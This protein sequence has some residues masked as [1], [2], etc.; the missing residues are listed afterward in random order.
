[1]T[2]LA[3]ALR[4]VAGNRS[5]RNAELAWF[6]AMSAQWAYFVAALVFAYDVGGVAAAGIAGTLRMLPAAFLAPF[7]TMLADRL[8]P[9][10]VL[11]WLNAGR[12]AAVAVIAIVIAS[13]L[14]AAVVFVAITLEGILSTLNR[15]THVSLLPALARSPQ[16]LVAANA[17]TSSGEALGMLIGPFVGGLFMAVGGT[18]LGTAVPALAFAAAALI[19]LRIERTPRTYRPPAPGEERSRLNELMAGFAAMRTYPAVGGLIALFGA[20]VFVRG[21]LTVLLVVVSVELLGLGSSGVGYLNAALGAG[22]LVGAF[23]AFTLVLRPSLALPFSAALGLWGIP[24]ILLGLA[25]QVLLAFL[26]MGVIGVANAV[27]D[28]S[29]ISLVQRSVPTKLRAR[30]FG[31]GEAILSLTAGIGSLVAPILVAFVSLEMAL[32]IVGAILPI[33]AVV[34]APLVR[35]AD[36]SAIVPH[37]ELELLRGVPMFA[38]LPLTALEQVAGG[39]VPERHE[40]GTEVIRQ[41]DR[42]DCWYLIAAGSV[43]VVHD[44][45]WL[46]TLNAGEAFGEI[47]LLSDRPRTATIRVRDTIDVLRLPRETFLEALTGSPRAQLAGDS[48]VAERLAEL[49]EVHR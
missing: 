25:P 23:A 41:G 38:P 5:I 27:M 12:F 47:A 49:D 10:L 32:V 34:S 48:V 35:R 24:I 7:T 40:A 33:L 44:G 29:G 1:M 3:T 42:G 9:R 2:A 14:P 11:F 45:E 39:L 18:A 19:V 43:D 13:G 36:A 4:E 20:Q 15:P 6:I 17:T 30:V 8:S 21:V 46:K 16:E 37:R 31:A 22:S 26:F 28:V